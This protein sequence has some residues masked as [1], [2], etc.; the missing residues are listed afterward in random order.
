MTPNCSTI[1]IHAPTR[2]ATFRI[3]IHKR[4][5][6]NFNPR[7]HAGGDAGFEFYRFSTFD[8]NPRPHAGGDHLT[9]I[10]EPVSMNFNPRPH[11]G[12]DDEV[13]VLARDANGIS[14]HAPTRGAT[15]SHT[16]LTARLKHFNPRPH[17]GGDDYAHFTRGAMVRFQSTPPRGG[18]RIGWAGYKSRTKFQSTPPRG[19]RRRISILSK[20]TTSISIHAPTRGA[21]REACSPHP[22]TARISI[23]APTR[24]ATTPP[25]TLARLEVISI[26]AP[27]RG[28][29]AKCPCYG[30]FLYF[31]Y[32]VLAFSFCFQNVKELLFCLLFCFC[33]ANLSGFSCVIYLRTK[34][35]A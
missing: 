6:C 21:T 25:R 9:A 4:I 27:T 8:F 17:A 34:S 22:T 35:T 1:S 32:I 11:A 13:V 2:G 10:V 20:A 18:R 30:T 5:C 29:T 15:T 19:G 16:T 26:H 31:I 14:I 7:P 28:A 12:G 3:S 23:H 24:G 33:G